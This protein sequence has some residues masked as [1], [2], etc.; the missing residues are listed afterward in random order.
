MLRPADNP[1]AAQRIDAMRYELRGMR[2]DDLLA[3]LERLN[4]R[5]AIIGPHG[6]GKTTLMEALGHRLA[7]DGW[8]IRLHRL[9]RDDRVVPRTFT[10]WLAPAT[11]LLLDSAGCLGPAG[12]LALLRRS[13]GA[14]GLIVTAHRRMLLPTLIRTSV[15][16]PMMARLVERLV[17]GPSP[18]SAGELAAMLRARQGNARQVLRD[19]YDRC[20]RSSMTAV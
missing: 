9:R 20:A 2:W 8:D 15:D 18:W 17:G 6:S 19:L 16:A 4:R 10:A 5:A 13:A 11:I 14:G 1:F 12:W 7:S 3:R